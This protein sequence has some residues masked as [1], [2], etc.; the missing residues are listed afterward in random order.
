MANDS[1]SA[2]AVRVLVVEDYEPFRR[3]ICTMLDRMPGLQI[4]G[5]VSDG[6]EADRKAEELQPDLV[7]M[8]VGWPPL[9]GLMSVRRI[10]TL[11]PASKIIV[12]TIESS[13]EVVE[14]AL[15]LGAAGYVVKTRIARDLPAAV[16]AVLRGRQFISGGLSA[17]EFPTQ[18]TITDI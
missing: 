5:D 14:A 12:V 1:R 13:S 9:N 6:I 18:V 7:L 15:S 17:Q 16:D 11:S 4:V 8:D 3:V 2:R 10:R